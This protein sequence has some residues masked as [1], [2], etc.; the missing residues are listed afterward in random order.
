M[1]SPK[2][3]ARTIGVFF[4]LTILC[5]IFAQGFVLERLVDAGSAAKTAANLRANESLFRLGYAVFM[6]EMACN[7]MMV[8]LFYFLYRPVSRTVA[9]LSASFG[10]VGVVIKTFGRVFFIVPLYVLGSS[11]ALVGFDAPQLAALTLVLARIDHQAGSMGLVFFGFGCLLDGWLILKST[12]LPRFLGVV[13]LVS[14]VGW[15]T[16]L[17]APLAGRL[18]PVVV[19][20]GLLG[21]VLMIFWLL[22][23]GVNESRWREQEAARLG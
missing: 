15:L 9:L 22:V 10:L 7:L 16:F 4:L 23:F 21:A 18:Y 2:R 14:G 12:F 1:T 17:Y 5:G 6:V 19:L 3:L 11:Q 20:F 13:S 8:M